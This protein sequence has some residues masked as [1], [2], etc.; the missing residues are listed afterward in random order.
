MLRFILADLGRMKA[1]ALVIVALVA[2]VVAL[3][4]AVTLQERALR[5]GSARAADKFELVIGAPGSETQLVLSTVF[6]Q[7]AALPLVGGDVLA[8]L[9]DDPRVAWAAPVGFGDFHDG[10][11]VIGTTA[12]VISET[13]PAM[14][15]G[16]MFATEGEAVAGALT[17]LAPG[18]EITPT[19]GELGHDHENV[20]YRIT[21]R[22]APTNTPWDRAIM[23]PIQSVWRVHGMAVEHDHAEDEGDGGFDP[24][25]ALPEGE[26]RLDA[27][28][29][30]DADDPVGGGS[31]GSLI[32]AVHDHAEHEGHGDVHPAAEHPA[33]SMGHD[34]PNSAAQHLAEEEGHGDLGHNAERPEESAGHDNSDSAEQEHARDEA[35]GSFHPDAPLPTDEDWHGAPGVPAILVK[36][37]TI[38][39]AYKLRQDYRAQEGTMAVFP[40]E[41]LTGLYATLGDA[42]QV[43]AAV[44]AAA[45]ALVAVALLLVTLTH[46]GQRRRQIG[47]LR[48]LGAPRGAIFAMVWGEL[49]ALAATGIALGLGAGIIAAHLLSGAI[50]QRQGFQ[51]PVTLTAGDLTGLALLLALAALLSALPAWLAYRQP[52]VASLRG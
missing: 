46:V 18:D 7:P 2:L 38:A 3:G 14:A 50:A 5:L 30:R 11:P 44:A 16:R 8:A 51:L 43:L 48:A 37:A 41:V 15:Q 12:R 39:D 34:S 40:A 49:F 31:P 10:A 52:P 1:G 20:R 32:P 42:R 33:E 47:A 24:D 45:Q 27:Q 28:A 22:L 6:L 19:H 35:H 29:E 9:H 36:P 26:D 25:A 23:V 13:A 17:G 4:V 21:G